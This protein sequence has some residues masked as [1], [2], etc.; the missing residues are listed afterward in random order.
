MKCNNCGNPVYGDNLFC[1]DCK[2]IDIHAVNEPGLIEYVDHGSMFK[3]QNGNGYWITIMHDKHTT[4][5]AFGKTVGECVKRASIM[6]ASSDM[7]N[8]LKEAKSIIYNLCNNLE[9]R[10]QHELQ[11]IID[12]AINK[13]YKI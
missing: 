4:A 6:A 1:D 3:N 10:S 8:T 5:R 11:A 13:A 2:E 7:L 9:T 12:T